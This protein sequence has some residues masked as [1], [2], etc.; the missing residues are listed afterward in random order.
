MGRIGRSM[1]MFSASWGVLREDKRL[2]VFPAIGAVATLVVVAMFAAPI[3]F[4]FVHPTTTVDSM[5]VEQTGFSVDPLGWVLMA[6]GYVIAMYVSTFMN[7]ALIIAAN[8]RL[9]GSGPGTVSSGLAGASEKAGAILGWVLVAATVGLALRALEERLGLVGRIVIGIIGIAWSLLTFLV[10][11]VLVL[12]Q[13]TT[14]TSISRSAKLFKS[15][16]GENL[17]GN[18]SF[19][20]FGFLLTLSAMALFFVGVLTG[21]GA[22]MVLMGVIAFLWLLVGA[23]VLATMSGVY[24]VAL[25]RYAVDGAPPR[26]YAAFDFTEAFRPKRS[27]G[28]FGSSRGR[29]VYRSTQ[30]GQPR[31]DPWK[32]WEPPPPEQTHGEFG[33]EI[34]GAQALP[35]HDVPRP[36]APPAS[37]TP[38]APTWPGTDGPPATGPGPSA[39]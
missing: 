19:G 39:F 21:T 37:S 30:T 32:A 36:S 14:G 1:Q 9:T 34:P 29:T 11:P 20:I 17:V 31:R 8:E 15:T 10:V 18:I 16:W 22:G 38:P 28:G 2:M 5:G 13:N 24:R 3:L 23:Q 26:A 7:A 27:W 6:I 35:G 33:I 12:E 25:Y 4:A